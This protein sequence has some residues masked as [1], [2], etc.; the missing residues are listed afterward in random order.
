VARTA[1]VVGAGIGGLAAALALRRAG[2]TVR[3]LEKAASPRELGFALSLAPNAVAALRELGVAD[4]VIR[5]GYA[6]RRVEFRAGGGRVLRRVDASHVAMESVVAMRPVVHGALV[7]AVGGDALTLSREAIGF[8]AA[9]A[10]VSV[11]CA[12]GESASGDVLVGADGIGSVIRRQLHPEEA[13]PQPSGYAAVRGAVEDIGAMLGDL[14]GVLYF[15]PRMEV[16]VVRAG[17]RS[18]YWYASLLEEDVPHATADAR[19]ISRHVASRLDE[20]FRQVVAATRDDDLR[21]DVL[22]RRAPLP[23]WGSGRVTLLGD[24]A[25]P[26]LPH[27]GQGAAQAMEDAVALGLALGRF[28]EVEPALRAYESVRAARTARFVALGPRIARV[29]TTGNPIITALRNATV[30]LAPTALIVKALQNMDRRDPHAA[31]REEPV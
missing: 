5:G 27:T 1:L 24:A 17:A 11:Q 30:R 13:P 25:H 23:W 28:P 29:T 12:S 6:A 22:Q 16:A 20:T 8:E 2:W 14:D 19:A 18:A 10:V 3:V 26:V 7:A 9:G 31:L 4:A 15:A 21:F